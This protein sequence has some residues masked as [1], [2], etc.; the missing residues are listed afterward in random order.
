MPHG[1]GPCR[2]GQ[3]YISLKDIIT[4]LKLKDIG[5]LSMDDEASFEDL[6]TDFFIKGWLAISIADVIH[7]IE[8]V[9][10]SLAVNKLAAL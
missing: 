10:Q 5:I 2:Q 7:D 1:Y 8:S 4:N 6:G 9:I 3:Y